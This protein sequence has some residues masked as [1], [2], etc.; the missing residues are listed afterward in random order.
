[1]YSLAIVSLTTG[2][3]QFNPLCPWLQESYSLTHCVP[4]YSYCRRNTVLAIVSMTTKMYGLSHCDPDC[5]DVRLNPLLSLTTEKIQFN[6]LCP[7]LLD[8]HSLT[9]CVPDYRK[10]TAC[11]PA[12]G[13]IQF[14][15]LC[16]WLQERYSLTHCV[17][18]CRRD[19]VLPSVALT[20]VEIQ[21]NPLCPWLQKRYSGTHCIPDCRRDSLT[22]DTV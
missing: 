15:P 19:T 14:N 22:Y 20:A 9:H 4:D 5:K 11:D 1:M 10:G 6:P 8:L 18:N 13:E 16:L 3:L 21:L 17:L 2:E 7:W 12:A